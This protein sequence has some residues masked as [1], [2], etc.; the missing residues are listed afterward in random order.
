MSTP[1]INYINILLLGETGV[2]KSTFINAFANYLTYDTLEQ[3]VNGQPLGVIPT[4]FV[5][6][7][8]NS[9]IQYVDYGKPDS[10]ESLNF[11]GHSVTQDCWAYCFKY[12]CHTIRLIDTPGVGDTRG[13]DQDKINFDNILRFIAHY[14]VLHLICIL[15]KPDTVR[16]TDG[17]KYCFRELLCHLQ[18]DASKNMIFLFTNSRNTYYSPGSTLM[19]LKKMLSEIKDQPPYVDIPLTPYTQYYLDNESFQCLIAMTKGLVVS[20]M[21]RQASIVSWDKSVAECTRLFN[22]IVN[23]STG[24]QPLVPH[25][26][27]DTLSINN[28]RRLILALAKPI[29]LITNIIELNMQILEQEKLQIRNCQG[30]IDQ[31]KHQQQV[32]RYKQQISFLKPIYSMFR[33]QSKINEESILDHLLRLNTEKRGKETLIRQYDIRI[34]D[35]KYEQEFIL[36]SVAKFALFLNHNA[37]TVCPDPFDDY[38]DNQLTKALRNYDNKKEIEKLETIVKDYRRVKN[39]LDNL[40]KMG[41]VNVQT[42]TIDYVKGLIEELYQLNETGAL[43]KQLHE[44]N[45]VKL[46]NQCK[47]MS[48][49]EID[50]NMPRSVFSVFRYN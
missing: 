28:T 11:D 18:K 9:Q 6:T 25:K 15:M 39:V 45:I 3:A 50:S 33:N 17:F 32:M 21:E 31:L 8:E 16:L 35:N 46:D 49:H 13:L 40:V 26:I 19:L 34:H 2:G 14:D 10:N 1:Q 12:N 27:Q 30:N 23:G 38:M 36:K 5:R 7:D 41:S 4:Q 37:L 20:E 43:I 47:R 24:F 22:Y 42:I 44:D 48:Y 29:F